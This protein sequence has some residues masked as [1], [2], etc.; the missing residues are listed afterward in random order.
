L[1]YGKLD[2]LGDAHYYRGRAFLLQDEDERAIAEFERAIKILGETS[3]RGQTVKD[4]LNFVRARR[5]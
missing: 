3:P 4:E 1:V 5:R 2:R